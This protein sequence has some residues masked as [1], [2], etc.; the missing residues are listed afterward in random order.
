VLNSALRHKDVWG[1]VGIAP[2]FLTS[3]LDGGECSASSLSC[4]TPGGNPLHPYQLDRRLDRPQRWYGRCEENKVAPE[5][6]SKPGRPARR[7]TNLI[8]YLYLAE[9]AKETEVKV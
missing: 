4:F 5:G 3:A 9:E 8:L 1:S 6:N 7:H 2:P